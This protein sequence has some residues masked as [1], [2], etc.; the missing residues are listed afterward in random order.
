MCAGME[1]CKTV[2]VPGFAPEKREKRLLLYDLK[3][4]YDDWMKNTTFDS[5][6]AFSYF[7]ALRPEECVTAG[8]PGT[9]TMCVPL[10]PKLQVKAKCCE[11][12]S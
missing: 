9:H 11:F 4:M 8:S 2:K 3:D 5:Y 10:S 12:Q 6:P 1:E 7:A